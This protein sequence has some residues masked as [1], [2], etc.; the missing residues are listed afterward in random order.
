MVNNTL[1]LTKSRIIAEGFDG[2]FGAEKA[3][4]ICEAGSLDGLEFLQRHLGEA[5]PA[6][7]EVGVGGDTV[8]G[9]LDAD[10]DVVSGAQSVAA[11]L[12]DG[13]AVYGTGAVGGLEDH[14]QEV[15]DRGYS[16]SSE[17]PGIDVDHLA[18]GGALALGHFIPGEGG[19][20]EENP[21]FLETTFE[22]VGY[23]GG[24]LECVAHTDIITQI[25]D[26]VK[27]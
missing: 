27:R 16:G 2:V 8:R 5:D 21:D 1:I 20:D 3:G 13:L 22:V 11:T 26:F 17:V 6:D 15:L 19:V 24:G 25:C 7:Q 4:T 9:V 10:P 23:W 12:A 18:T 14:V